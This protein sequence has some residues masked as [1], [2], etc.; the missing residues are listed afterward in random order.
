MILSIDIETARNDRAFEYT[1]LAEYT[2]P[3]NIKDPA[4]IAAAIEEKKKK[5]AD[6]HALTWWTGR[7]ISCALVEV[8]NG[9]NVQAVIK[10]FDEKKLLIDLTDK[11]Q[12][13][14][15]H[16]LWGKNSK[17]FD[18]PFLVGRYMANK[19]PV[20]PVLKLRDALKD[21]DDIFGFSSASSQRGKLDAYFFGLGLDLKLMHGSDIGPLWDQLLLARASQDA[22]TEEMVW[23]QITE[24]NLAD[25]D[26]TAEIVKRYKGDDLR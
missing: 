11:L 25:A 21:I 2:A 16:E 9:I 14:G 4:K 6:Q 17:T 20:P 10:N 18:F 3:G 24:Y 23:K 15:A 12:F 13:F 7:V 8:A 19:I 22:Q 1:D 26:G 5:A